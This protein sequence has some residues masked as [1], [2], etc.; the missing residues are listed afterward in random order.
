MASNLERF[1]DRTNNSS[2][3]VGGANFRNTS[4]LYRY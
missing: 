1:T 2:D 4:I 3:K